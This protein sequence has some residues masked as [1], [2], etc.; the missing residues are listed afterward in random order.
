MLKPVFAEVLKHP[1]NS[2]S[3]ANFSSSEKFSKFSSK[4]SALLSTKRQGNLPPSKNPATS[5][6]EDFH[7]KV[8]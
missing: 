1:Q 3:S 6:T 8:L 2:L 5:S 7:F 4:R